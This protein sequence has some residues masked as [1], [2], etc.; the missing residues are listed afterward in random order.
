MNRPH[1]SNDQVYP[2]S[3]SNCGGNNYGNI[4]QCDRVTSCAMC[5]INTH[6]YEQFGEESCAAPGY[7]PIYKG[8]TFGPHH[9]HRANMPRICMDKQQQLGVSMGGQ[10]AY[11]YPTTI[12][13]NSGA[14]R[15]QSTNLPC[16]LCC[17]VQ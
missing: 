1:S 15:S 9:S 7:E 13:G 2:L 5:K 11:I 10:G 17:K 6:C 12:N 4:G 3:T 8:I 14:G 16:A